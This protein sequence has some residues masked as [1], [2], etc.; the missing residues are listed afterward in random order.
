MKKYLIVTAFLTFAFT[1]WAQ[2][3]LGEFS[4]Y[5]KQAQNTEKQSQQEVVN[6]LNRWLEVNYNLPEAS[7]ALILKANLEKNLKEY[8]QFITTLLRYKYEFGLNE[9]NNVQSVLKDTARDFSKSEQE[10]YNKLISARV[11]QKELAERLDAFLNVATKANIK[12]TYKPLQ[13]EYFSFF[14]RFKDYE[15]I[16]RLE[17]MLGDLHRNNKNPYAALM[18]YEKV[19]SI[20]PNTKYKAASLRMQGDVY[21]SD[22][23]DYQK[24]QSIY[25]QVL[26][27]FPDS[28]EK[29]TAYYH[30]ALME[31]SQKEYQEALDHLNFAAKLYQEQGDT[32]SLYNVLSFKADIQ[33]KK[34]KDYE[35]AANTLNNISQLFVN[36]GNIYEE[37]QF[38]LATLYRN[39]LKNPA[40]EKKAYEDL[41]KN[42]P[43]SQ[44]A[45]KA[46]FEAA[47]LAKEDGQ[48]ALA[49]NYLEKLIVNNPSS[50]YAGKAQRQINSIEKQIAKNQ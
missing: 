7:K 24:A 31:E 6:N 25:E 27:D 22:L 43:N 8:P 35:G 5:Q 21:A 44:N 29:P 41:L 11:P 49:K 47:S 16:D 39:K 45:D 37:N 34:L 3:P 20:Y 36:K 30:L 50:V 32:S 42:Y 4:F 12:G 19:W 1:A 17:L 18:Q 10:E 40:L 28:V 9:K 2:N 15:E 33:E 46:L 13:E 23:K 26:T 14:R 38:K 48:Y